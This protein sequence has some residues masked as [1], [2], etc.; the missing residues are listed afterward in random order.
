M[1]QYVILN[2]ELKMSKGKITRLAVGAGFHIKSVTTLFDRMK[3]ANNNY[4]TV[5]IKSHDNNFNDVLGYLKSNKIKHFIH[6]DAGHTQ[7]AKGSQCMV[8]FLLEKDNDMFK[9]FRLY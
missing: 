5:V 8:T 1:K 2:D 6:V 4:N 7:V 9:S 3:W